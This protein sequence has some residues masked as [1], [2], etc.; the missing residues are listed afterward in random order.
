MQRAAEK[1]A[2]PA[3]R[4]AG[5]RSV[6]R[7]Q[8]RRERRGAPGK[9]RRRKSP[10][11]RRERLLAAPAS[12]GGSV[13]PATRLPLRAETSEWSLRPNLPPGGCGIPP[14]EDVKFLPGGVSEDLPA[15]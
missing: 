15:A 4:R 5:L 2:P 13:W 9:R 11:S 1:Q 12:A 6:Y 3:P 7:R 14:W 8:N 10:E